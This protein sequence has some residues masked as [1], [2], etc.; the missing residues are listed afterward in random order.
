MLYFPL[1]ILLNCSA[2]TCPQFLC[3]FSQHSY[4]YSRLLFLLHH[5]GRYRVFTSAESRSTVQL[6]IFL[7]SQSSALL[8][9][10]QS[11]SLDVLLELCQLQTFFERMGGV[12]SSFAQECNTIGES[13]FFLCCVF[14]WF[15]FTSVFLAFRVWPYGISIVAPRLSACLL[16]IAVVE[17]AFLNRAA[18][19]EYIHVFINCLCQI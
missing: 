15:F 8:V 11:V 4:I 10:R 17:R 5:D 2:L 6:Y 3:F 1:H 19:P 14:F 7:Y 12:H 9:S 13:A 16:W 18:T